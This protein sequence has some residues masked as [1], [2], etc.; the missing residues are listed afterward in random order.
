MIKHVILLIY[1]LILF[2]CAANGGEMVI[3]VLICR[4]KEWNPQTLKV[5][6]K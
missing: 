4:A 2:H 5:A 6:S 3:G 1:L